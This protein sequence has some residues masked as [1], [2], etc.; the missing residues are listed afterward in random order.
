VTYL[1]VGDGAMRQ[2][3][4][5]QATERQLW[6]LQVLPLQRREMFLE[7]LAAADLCLVTQQGTVADIVFPSKVITLLAAGR[8]VVAS[9]NARSEVARV[10]TEAGAGVV[11]PPEEPEALLGTIVVLWQETARRQAMGAR[12]RAYARQ[13]WDRER[14]LPL[15]EAGLLRLTRKGELRGRG[16]GRSSGKA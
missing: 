13:Q 16:L 8:P 5:A 6:N 11:V 3:L 1:L 7:L 15:L 14:I 10:I 9:V 12:G 4:E 2:T